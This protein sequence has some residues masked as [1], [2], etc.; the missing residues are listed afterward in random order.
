MLIKDLLSCH[1]QMQS[2]LVSSADDLDPEV[3][4]LVEAVWREAM[5]EID[6]TL[7]VSLTHIKPKQVGWYQVQNLIG[8]LLQTNI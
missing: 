5:G 4:A 7:S 6:K 2:E 3:A 1:S 8:N